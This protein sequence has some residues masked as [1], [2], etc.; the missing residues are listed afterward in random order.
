M[1]NFVNESVDRHMILDLTN[2]VP[3]KLQPPFGLQ[4]ITLTSKVLVN[5]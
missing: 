5:T 4:K 2:A 3:S 1:L